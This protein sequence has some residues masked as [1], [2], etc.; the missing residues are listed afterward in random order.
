MLSE[1]G[2]RGFRDW[3]EL[4]WWGNSASAPGIPL[5]SCVGLLGSASPFAVRKGTV[6]SSAPGDHEGSRPL[7]PS[8]ISPAE[9]GKPCR[10]TAPGIP[11]RS[12]FARSRPLSFRKGTCLN[13]RSHAVVCSGLL[14]GLPGGRS[15]S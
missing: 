7:C 11:L 8:D 10:P 12:R 4:N 1:L 15:G 13:L 6:P 2:L 9:R 5:R 14:P 3:W